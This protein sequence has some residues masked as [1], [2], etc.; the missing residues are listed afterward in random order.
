MSLS[1]V[2]K[3][4]CSVVHGNNAKMEC[5]IDMIKFVQALV[6][7]TLLTLQDLFRGKV[8]VLGLSKCVAS[9]MP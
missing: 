9:A 5:F 3:L 2:K 4:A 6:C 8:D 1:N 7:S